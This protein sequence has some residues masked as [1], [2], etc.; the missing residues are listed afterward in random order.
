MLGGSRTGSVTCSARAVITVQ[1]RPPSQ[2]SMSLRTCL[3][4]DEPGGVDA[5]G[6]HRHHHAGCFDG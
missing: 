3:L 5:A 1:V 4:T 2:S 6:R